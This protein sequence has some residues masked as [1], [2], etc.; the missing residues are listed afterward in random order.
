MTTQHKVRF[1]QGHQW[2]IQSFKSEDAAGG[3]IRWCMQKGV[4]AA[5]IANPE[6]AQ[7]AQ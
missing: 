7:V 5:R 2:H 6:P 3:F 1:Y 4:A